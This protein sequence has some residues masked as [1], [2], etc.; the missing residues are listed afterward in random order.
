MVALVKFILSLVIKSPE[1]IKGKNKK[2]RLIESQDQGN[3]T[4]N[5]L[6][7]GLLLIEKKGS[8][9]EPLPINSSIL[10]F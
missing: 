7:H 3:N 4:K 6:K 9:I 1:L 2:K 10:E 5:G 8:E